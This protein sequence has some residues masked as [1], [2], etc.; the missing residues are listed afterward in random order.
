LGQTNTINL[1]DIEKEA[2]AHLLKEYLFYQEA[3]RPRFILLGF[4]DSRNEIRREL[5]KNKI[6]VIEP[7]LTGRLKEASLLRGKSE[8]TCVII[9]S[10]RNLGKFA[11]LITA[12]KVLA[13]VINVERVFRENSRDI[14]DLIDVSRWLIDR[15]LPNIGDFIESKIGKLQS[16]TNYE[17]AKAILGEIWKIAREKPSFALWLHPRKISKSIVMAVNQSNKGKPISVAFFLRNLGIESKATLDN[18]PLFQKDGLTEENLR[19]LRATLFGYSKVLRHYVACDVSTQRRNLANL[20]FNHLRMMLCKL[21][22]AE[23]LSASKGKW[24]DI[25]CDFEYAYREKGKTYKKY[26][27]EPRGVRIR[28]R[29]FVSGLPI[30]FNV[31]LVVTLKEKGDRNALKEF[32]AS[33]LDKMTQEYSKL[34]RLTVSINPLTLLNEEKEI[35]VEFGAL[36]KNGNIELETFLNGLKSPTSQINMLIASIGRKG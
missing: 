33:G 30:C 11:S 34:Q 15:G 24:T 26:R 20:C 5:G 18:I 22:K 16:S 25:F 28:K 29:S 6:P 31:P 8:E 12:F 2:Y 27:V 9:I 10:R 14:H 3:N 1:N 36:E 19:E 23:S 21:A 4:D 35:V 7:E 17:G 13:E 32:M